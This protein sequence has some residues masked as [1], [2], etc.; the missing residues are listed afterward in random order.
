MNTSKKTNTKKT[1]LIAMAL[2]FMM[3]AMAQKTNDK[4]AFEQL[5][6]KYNRISTKY[7]N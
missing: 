3:P 2:C 4:T 7:L 6:K 5:K 1:L